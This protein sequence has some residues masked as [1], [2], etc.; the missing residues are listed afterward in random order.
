MRWFLL[1]VIS[2]VACNQAPPKPCELP[3]P[4]VVEYERG[5][6]PPHDPM[7]A[8]CRAEKHQ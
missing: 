2:L 3:K 1:T 4:A 5:Y 7:L 8:S 6:E